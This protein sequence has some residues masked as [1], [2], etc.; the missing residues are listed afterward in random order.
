VRVPGLRAAQR[1]LAWL[2]CGGPVLSARDRA[3]LLPSRTAAETLGRTIEQVLLVERWRPTAG[4]LARLDIDAPAGAIVWPDLVTRQE[5]HA[6]LHARAGDLAPLLTDVEREVLL[7]AAAGEALRSGA[8]PPFAVRPG[9]VAAMLDL[10][11]G[12]ARLRRSPSDFERLALGELEPA[13]DADRGAARLLQQTRFMVA[14]FRDYDARVERSG[15]LDERRLR[16]ALIDAKPPRPFRHLVLAV[17]DQAADPVGL[18]PADYDLLL[19]LP[20]LERIDVVATELELAAGWHERLLDALPGIE[21]CRLRDLDEAPPLLSAPE[22]AEGR[23][24]FTSRDREEEL[25]DLVRRLKVRAMTNGEAGSEPPS[26]L[27]DTALVYQKPLPY[28]YLA[29]RVFGEARV[30]FQATDALPLAAEPPAAALDLVLRCVLHDFERPDLVGLLGS[31]H[32]DVARAGGALAADDTRALDRW[33]RKIGFTSGAGVLEERLR[34][35]LPE[36]PGLRRAA[37]AALAILAALAPL[38]DARS[39]TGQLGALQ[40]FLESYGVTGAV[41]AEPTRAARARSAVRDVLLDLARAHA[42]FDDREAPLADTGALVRR[43]IEARTVAPRTGHAGV[44]LVDT[45]AAR[46]GRFDAVHLLGL[47]EGEWPSSSA[48]S[49]FYP[50]ALLRQLGWP[51]EA[52][53]MRAA[54]AAFLDMLGAARLEASVSTF[55]LE[56]DTLVRPAVL[57]ED[58]DQSALPVRRVE[59]TPLARVFEHEAL[60]L[61][62]VDAAAVAGE[63][64]SWLALRQARSDAARPAYHGQTGPYVRASHSPTALDTYRSCP[65]KYF[66]S[67]VLAIDEERDDEIGLDPLARG[68]LVHAV[69]ER[70]F[71]WWQREGRGAV[72]AATLDDARRHFAELV[73]EMLAR[74]PEADRQVESARLLGSAAGEGMGDRVFRIEAS[75]EARVVARELEL[76]IDGEYTFA[77]ERGDRTVRLR[78]A[79]DRVDRLDDGTLRVIDYKSGAVGE[80]KELLQ[81]PLYV[82]VIE[83]AIGARAGREVQASEAFYVGLRG[84]DPVVPVITGAA[85]RAERLAAAAE[86]LVEVV[87]GIAA[88][89]FPPRPIRPRL[90]ATCGYDTVCRK[91]YVGL[92]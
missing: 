11:D 62:P 74:L 26:R 15:R 38:T 13:A 36:E 19:T 77:A 43:W 31:P 40:E 76:A 69:F 75:R 32:F 17:G 63:A 28:L 34:G 90:C 12:L 67:R 44:H 79:V 39:V 35:G 68:A 30:P 22:Q 41:G 80:L 20:G 54:R 29:S 57:L 92:D 8:V 3:V 53:R 9:I 45:C 24:H 42:S 83:R 84:R 2:A 91:D 46:F 55:I 6:R 85:Q 10:F 56:E 59:A 58:V 49:I 81:V 61:V 60:S 48:R 51:G 65:F 14:A 73:S 4:D 66:A 82:Y 89:D 70:F 71:S 18:W 64:A 1:A 23:L 52:D 37:G 78:G 16:S 72:T 7:R 88:G 21:E 50:S 27:S 86:T 47:I 25:S 33:L 5:F 87:D